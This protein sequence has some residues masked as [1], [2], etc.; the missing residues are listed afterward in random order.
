MD[1]SWSARQSPEFDFAI[2]SIKL[3]LISSHLRNSSYIRSTHGRERISAC[4]EPDITAIRELFRHWLGSLF[5]F[6]RL[7]VEFERVGRETEI[8]SQVPVMASE[9]TS[10]I[11]RCTSP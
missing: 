4:G 11:L 6:L 3:P 2:P 5:V 8:L 1:P 9:V 10:L 7:F